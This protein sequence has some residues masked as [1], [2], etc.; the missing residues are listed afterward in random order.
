MNA[1]TNAGCVNIGSS[2]AN[3][4][5]LGAD[6]KVLCA[7]GKAWACPGTTFSSPT[8]RVRFRDDPPWMGAP[9]FF[10]CVSILFI[11]L[12]FCGMLITKC[13]KPFITSTNIS[14]ASVFFFNISLLCLMVFRVIRGHFAA[15][16]LNAVSCLSAVLRR[17]F[18]SL[19]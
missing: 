13:V 17:I 19:A 11:S 16:F 4:A 9:R 15:F 2:C 12:L 6:G 18:N 8:V 5:L 14:I 10:N 7:D 3:A 1:K